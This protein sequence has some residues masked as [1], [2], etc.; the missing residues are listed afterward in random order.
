M[1]KFDIIIVGAGIL[2]LSTAYHLRQQNQ[3]QRILLID[4]LPRAAQGDA[5]KTGELGRNFFSEN[6]YHVLT[7]STMDFY[8][9]IPR[10][11]KKV[12][13]LWLF[14]DKEYRNISS[15]LDK[16]S[17]MGIQMRF[18]EREELAGKLKINVE[19]SSDEEA[20]K[21]GLSDVE[22][23]V[24]AC[25]AGILDTDALTKFYENGFKRSK[26]ETLYNTRVTNLILK[27]SP[28]LGIFGEPFS[29]QDKKITGVVTN[30]GNFYSDK[31][32]LTGGVWNSSL[33][34][35]LGIYYDVKPG[36]RQIF[37]VK[38][39]S[40]ELRKLLEVK[41]FNDENQFPVVIPP[42]K[43][44]FIQGRKSEN[45]F[46]ISYRGYLGMKSE[47]EDDPKPHENY[48]YYGA[49]PLV[50]KYFPQFSGSKIY[51]MWAGMHVRM[52]SEEFCL[53]EL[54]NLL[55]VNAESAYC[56][57]DS[58]GRIAAAICLDRKYAQLFG[59]RQIRVDDLKQKVGE[60][61]EVATF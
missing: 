53:M 47:L 15:A 8:D 51:N 61:G 12:G 48:F 6:I 46:W 45:T 23:G 20:S 5:A 28:E 33:L 43:A 38:A 25:K 52:T 39:D 19:I 32:V 11:L 10:V 42:F 37:V 40:H 36:K 49:L 24:L 17:K 1:Q 41:G 31:V 29:W 57:G 50:A 7:D 34:D 4:K 26:G 21:M 59:G 13:Y 54:G 58:I 27:G 35:P 18:Y 3:N 30:R 60:K 16:M 2:G 22:K 56:F 9:N 14:S 55:V 44:F